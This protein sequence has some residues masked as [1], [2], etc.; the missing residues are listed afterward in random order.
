MNI[1][2]DVAMYVLDETLSLR[3]TDNGIPFNPLEDKPETG[4][5]STQEIDTIK[6]IASRTEYLRVI[7]MN[8]TT[9]E[10]DMLY[11]RLKEGGTCL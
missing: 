7:D 2:V 6:L 8:Y 3:L 9:I 5:F 11:C 10:I 4:E 1:N